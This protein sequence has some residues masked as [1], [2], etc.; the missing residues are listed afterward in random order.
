MELFDE[1]KAQIDGK[2]IRI[3]LP[4]GTEPRVLGTEGRNI[5]TSPTRSTRSYKVSSSR[6]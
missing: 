4:E 3:V 6:K 5:G 2:N 1:L